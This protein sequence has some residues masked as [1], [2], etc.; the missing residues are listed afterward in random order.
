M[1]RTRLRAAVL[2]FLFVAIVFASMGTTAEA[3]RNENA[4]E[5]KNKKECEVPEVPWTLVLPVASVG[6][7][8]AY[9]LV[10]RRRYGDESAFE[11]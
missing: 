9:Y 4:C 11:A 8:A 5:G 2:V 10:Q 1:M 7:A 3:A 6:L